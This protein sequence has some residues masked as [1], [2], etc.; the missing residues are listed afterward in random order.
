MSLPEPLSIGFVL[1]PDYALMSLASAVEPLRAANHLAGRTLYRCSFHSVAGGFLA[2][3]SG[4]GFHT[5]PLSVA[6][7]IPDL[8]LVV[9]GGNPMLYEDPALT[10]A[11]RGLA[12]RGVRL[13]GISGGAAILAKAGLMAGR[14]FTVH[15][16]HIDPLAEY[17]P[18]LLIER[19]LYVIDRDR[20][21]CA[22]GV[23]AMDMM[24]ALIARGQGAAFAREVS[25]WFIHP[26]LRLADE[27]QR[28][29]AAQRFN[30]HH[31]VLEAAVE[32]MASHL[33][34]PLSPDQLAAL[35]GCSARQLQRLFTGRFGLSMMTFYR[36]L[37]LAKADELLQQTALPLIEISTM[38]GFGN[39]SHFT[40]CFSGK[41][42][43]PPA[44]K[45]RAAMVGERPVPARPKRSAPGART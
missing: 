39:V 7:A 1:T 43:V 13:G 31:P 16:A 3:T 29:A 22:G 42:G 21:T 4:G 36:D 44:Q 25:D 28:L 24:G 12:S 27:P 18:D 6:G 8:V 23:A 20:Y 45:R 38:T 5:E 40:R 33:A 15:W 11:L 19:A 37:R 9:A 30:L 34:D 41:F 14:R 35:S 10:Q 32:L 26:R 2:S 17:A